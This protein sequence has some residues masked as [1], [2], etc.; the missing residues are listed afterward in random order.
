[1]RR[2]F[3][4]AILCM[5]AG[6]SVRAWALDLPPVDGKPM[7]LDVT[8][9]AIAKWH[10]VSRDNDVTNDNYGEWIN[11]LDTKLSWW[12]MTF[13]F[14]LDSVSYYNAPTPGALASDDVNEAPPGSFTKQ[15][16]LHGLSK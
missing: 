5:V 14:R 12:R 9:T 1:M 11:R 4:A 13:G 3:A 6:G 7:R 15:T 16:P 8:E 10:A 2:A